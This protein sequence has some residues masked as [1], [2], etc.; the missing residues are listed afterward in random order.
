MNFLCKKLKQAILTLGIFCTMT[1]FASADALDDCRDLLMSGN[2]SL[3]YENVTPPT[4]EAMNEKVLMYDGKLYNLTNPYTLYKPVEGI[5][6]AAGGNMY[7]ETNSAMNV[8]NFRITKE[9]LATMDSLKGTFGYMVG[10]GLTKL[11]NPKKYE[12]AS[13]TLKKNGETFVFTRITSPDKVE[14]VGHKKGKVE[15]LK[16]KKG[17]KFGYKYDFGN[18]DVTKVLNAI[19][20]NDTKIEGTITYKRVHSGT[21]PNGQYYV[22]LKAEQLAPN[23]I[24][25]AIRYYFQDDKLIKIEAGQYYVTKTGKLDGTRT[26]INIYEFNSHPDSKYFNLPKGLKDVTKRKKSKGDK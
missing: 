7:V 26:I 2:Y 1:N 9:E 25:D 5:V 17:F 16:I 13:C 19:L 20:P 10:S 18:D 4:R 3:R 14:Y 23:M 22:D 15:A 21:L 6:M 8:Q 12:Y 11:Y 24:F